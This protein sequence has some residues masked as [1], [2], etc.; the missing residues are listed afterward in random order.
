MWF[1]EQCVGPNPQTLGC[2]SG[3]WELNHY[4]TRPAPVCLFLKGFP[5]DS[6]GPLGLRTTA[7]GTLARVTYG[8]TV[9]SISQTITGLQIV[10]YRSASR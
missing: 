6:N 2:P 8:N 1:A 3:A 4:T 9:Q 5:G 7:R 10:P